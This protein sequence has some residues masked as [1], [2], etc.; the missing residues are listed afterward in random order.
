VELMRELGDRYH[1]ARALV[2]LG[3]NHETAGQPDD[4]RAAWLDAVRLLDEIGH[5]D[6]AEVRARLDGAGGRG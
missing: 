2:S 1:E 6:A 4:A 3:D 5:A